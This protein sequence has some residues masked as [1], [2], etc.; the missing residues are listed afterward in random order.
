[1]F[2]IPTQSPITPPQRVEEADAIKSKQGCDVV[3]VIG[4]D[5]LADVEDGFLRHCGSRDIKAACVTNARG[6]HSDT[7]ILE[8]LSPQLRVDSPLFLQLHGN[9]HAD[10]QHY[11]TLGTSMRTADLLAKLRKLQVPGKDGKM[12]DYKGPII[13]TS[14]KIGALNTKGLEDKGPFF[15]AGGTEPTNESVNMK[16][17][18]GCINRIEIGNKYQSEDYWT[19]ERGQQELFEV[20]SETREQVTLVKPDSCVSIQTSYL[21][22]HP[23]VDSSGLEPANLDE[24]KKSH[25]KN[26]LIEAMITNNYDKIEQILQFSSQVPSCKNIVNESIPRKW[27]A[28]KDNKSYVPLM[29]AAARQDEKMA[30]ILIKY[31]ADINIV[32]DPKTGETPL[33][34]AIKFGS[35]DQ[36]KFY[37]NSGAALIAK[38][39]STRAEL[40]PLVFAVNMQKTA[41]QN[42]ARKAITKMITTAVLA[43]NNKLTR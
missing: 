21:P 2:G 24:A 3:M 1:M 34:N 13:I 32:M 25:L 23:E 38:D 27:D 11:V 4:K 37:I 16:V 33:L 31:G 6:Q 22:F 14:C 18:E 35:V 42:N 28:S 41:P 39:K 5:H 17:I 12:G 29:V 10:G 43:Q 40:I 7:E 8:Q 26:T 15:L 36:V 20:I 19:S 30:K 9:V